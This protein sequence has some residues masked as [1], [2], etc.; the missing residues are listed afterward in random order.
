MKKVVSPVP[1][2]R[3]QGSEVSLATRFIGPIEKTSIDSSHCP[4]SP[5]PIGRGEECT[6][7]S[8]IPLRL[9]PFGSPLRDLAARVTHFVPAHHVFIHSGST[10]LSSFYNKTLHGDYENDSLGRGSFIPI[11]IIQSTVRL[12]GVEGPGRIV[13]V[14]LSM[15][16]EGE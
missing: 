3:Y 13:E 7:L 9:I 1:L 4:S 6:L 14:S 10:D 2:S 5:L 11:A 12:L 16:G 8:I 15:R